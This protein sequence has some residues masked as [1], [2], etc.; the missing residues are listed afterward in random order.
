MREPVPI[1]LEELNRILQ[2]DQ[3]LNNRAIFALQFWWPI[4]IHVLAC[5]SRAFSP[6]SLPVVSQ[7]G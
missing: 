1:G 7:H 4:C 5:A 6:T 2:N 3:S